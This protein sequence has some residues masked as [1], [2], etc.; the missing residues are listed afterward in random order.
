[1]AGQSLGP[2]RD[3]AA[4][5]LPICPSSLRSSEHLVIQHADGGG[6]RFGRAWKCHPCAR[7]KVLPMC[8]VAQ[9]QAPR[10]SSI[11]SARVEGIAEALR[12]ALDSWKRSLLADVMVREVVG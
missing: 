9:P 1:M 12:M 10:L 4:C 5:W 7:S 2:P 6:E 11:E 3:R 8:R